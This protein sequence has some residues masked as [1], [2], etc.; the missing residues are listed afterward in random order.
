MITSNSLFSVIRYCCG[1]W[2]REGVGL[3]LLDLQTCEMSM[4][5]LEMISQDSKLARFQIYEQPY[6]SYR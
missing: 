3:C 4:V 6:C 2:R 1:R 5:H